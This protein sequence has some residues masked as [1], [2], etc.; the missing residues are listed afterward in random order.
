MPL[1][2]EGWSANQLPQRWYNSIQPY[3]RSTQVLI[4]P[5]YPTRQWP[6]QP[7]SYA[8]N[9][10]YNGEWNVMGC[11]KAYT[12]GNP[13]EKKLPAIESTVGTV[14]L[15]DGANTFLAKDQTAIPLGANAT[16]SPGFD[17]W[18]FRHLETI[19][20]AFVDGHV[21]ALKRDELLKTKGTC[22]V[23]NVPVYPYFTIKDD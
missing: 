11:F 17:Q 20:A 3:L 23:N 2:E 22:G 12:W 6:G 21:K 9:E 15:T 16:Y 5:S 13:L 1:R 8:A 18:V 4:C 7:T 10:G 14:L 19:N